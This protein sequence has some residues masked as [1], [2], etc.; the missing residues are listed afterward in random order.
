MIW[1]FAVAPWSILRQAL[2]FSLVATIFITYFVYHSAFKDFIDAAFL[3]NL[4]T[5]IPKYEASASRSLLLYS[6]LEEI[7]LVLPLLIT[8]ALG[9]LR[10]A[11][12]RIL[13]E[14]TYL[15]LGAAIVMQLLSSVISAKVYHQYFIGL[16]PLTLLTLSHI[17]AG[18]L[19]RLK[20]RARALFS[21]LILVLVFIIPL[22]RT[23][24]NLTLTLSR[25]PHL[26][27]TASNT[28]V[29]DALLK[30]LSGI[31]GSFYL[32]GDSQFLWLNTEHGIIAPSR[33]VYQHIWAQLPAW[34]PQAT[35]VSEILAS[36]DKYQTRYILVIGDVQDIFGRPSLALAVE[37]F[38]DLKYQLIELPLQGEWKVYQRQH[39]HSAGPDF[40]QHL[41]SAHFR[42]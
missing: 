18:I 9:P 39:D 4:N 14:R 22:Y 31:R 36:L 20:I 24:N 38:L 21:A 30:D 8:L 28:I 6:R 11:G 16:A 23:V 42:P 7:G 2:G 34:D 15:I 41:A 29:L 35:K 12:H 3:F 13:S 40:E 26:N 33:W 25:S 32:I 17:Q 19:A 1:T 10:I 37:R 27:S 5:Y